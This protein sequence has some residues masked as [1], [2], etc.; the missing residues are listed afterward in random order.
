[1][2]DEIIIAGLSGAM[3]VLFFVLSGMV[4]KKVTKGANVNSLNL[5]GRL[6][7]VGIMVGMFIL[8]I[9]ILVA[10]ISFII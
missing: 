3:I 8:Y 5:P 1:M 7:V 9:M 10:L 4:V 2:L 6:K